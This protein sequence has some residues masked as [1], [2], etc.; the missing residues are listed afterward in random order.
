MSSKSLSDRTKQEL[1]TLARRRGVKGWDGMKKDQLV[2]AL[3]RAAAKANPKVARPAAKTP[4]A[5][6]RP[7]ATAQ[8]A[9]KAT[10]AKATVNGAARHVNGAAKQTAALPAKPAAKPAAVAPKPTSRPEP[11]PRVAPALAPRYE[12]VIA[13]DKDL[14]SRASKTGGA[15]K[16]RIVVTAPDP[17][18]LHAFWELSLQSVQRAEAALGQDWHGAKPIIRLFDVTSAD[19]TSTSERPL[20]DIVV[21]GGCTHWYIDVPQPPQSYR[22][23]IGY[24]SRRGQFYVLA[25]S[26]VIVPP[27]AGASEMVEEGGEGRS[28]AA[29]PMQQAQNLLDEQFRKPLVKDT[30]FGSGALPPGKLKKFFFD[31]DAE[32]IVRGQTDPGAA[33]TLQNEPVKLTP[34]GR[35]TMRFSLP[36]SRQIIPAVATAADGMEEQTIVLAVERNTKRLDPMIHDL[37]GEN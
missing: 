32:L 3:N 11:A 31:I 4:P 7:Q 22:A 30:A 10:P 17:Y 9:A 35:F 1:A 12:F 15:V 24:L 34:D 21:H 33:V 28:A 2:R 8:P 16:D 23:D 19:T 20:R 6:A 27:K 37:Y 26:N 13:A 5:K 18:W 36:D 25:R 29:D 14:S